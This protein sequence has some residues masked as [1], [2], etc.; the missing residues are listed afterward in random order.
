MIKSL[1]YLSSSLARATQAMREEDK[2]CPVAKKN[3][4]YRYLGPDITHCQ[5]IPYKGKKIGGEL[6]VQNLMDNHK[7]SPTSQKNQKNFG[8]INKF[9]HFSFCLL[10]T[11]TLSCSKFPLFLFLAE[12]IHLSMYF[13]K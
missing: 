8:R 9:G 5:N 3:H 4:F 1:S 12:M 11:G 6:L 10:D 7:T 2:V 13:I